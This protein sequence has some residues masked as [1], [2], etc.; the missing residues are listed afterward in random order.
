MI[1][2]PETKEFIKKLNSLD[3][4]LSVREK[5]RD[6]ME[7]GYCA[8]AKLTAL[9]QERADELEARYMRI[10]GHYQDKDTVRAYPELLEMVQS[11]VEGGGVDFLGSVAGQL[12]VLDDDKGQ[13]FTP[14]SVSKL[15]AHMN[16]HDMGAFI[17]QQGYFTFCEPACGAGSLVLAAADVVQEM[18][19][20]PTLH[21]LVQATDISAI[22][23]Y[24]AYLQLTFRGISA[25]VIRGDTIR[26]EQFESA[27][28]VPAMMFKMRHGHLSFT[29]SEQLV[30]DVP[31]NSY[32]VDMSTP[33]PV[34]D[35]PIPD[36]FPSASEMVQLSLFGD[37]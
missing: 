20:N 36:K 28:T 27:W 9:T 15:M 37:G 34:I 29:K 24:M 30:E 11:A 19:Y 33:Q 17:E 18:G 8:Y 3:H 5:F 13:I 10:V 25:G 6:L 21:M 4:S 35:F 32:G 23:Y 7:M 2:T 16:L 26:L 31:E 1:E 12:N 22:A 14:Y